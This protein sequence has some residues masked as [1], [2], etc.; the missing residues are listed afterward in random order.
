MPI[1]K[2][3]V[4]GHKGMV[5]SAITQLLK[6]NKIKVFTKTRIQL[7]LTNQAKVYSYLKRTK[8]DCVI[9]AAAKV[10]GIYANDTKPANFL[11]ENLLIES[12]LIHGAYKAGVRRL[13]FLGSSCIY[14]KKTKQPIKEEQLLTGEL[15]LTNYAYAIA[16]IAGIKLCESYNIQ[17]G[18]DFR[19]LMP[20]NLYGPG[21]NYHPMDSHV[22]PSLIRKFHEAKINNKKEV[23]VWGTGKPRREFL[24]VTD[25]AKACLFIMR[26]SKA[27]YNKLT[28]KHCSHINVGYGTD[29]TINELAKII[30]NAV[31]FKGKIIFNT[32][33]KD[34]TLRK[35]LDSTKIKKLGW[36]PEVQLQTGLKL[37]YDHF[38]GR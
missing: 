4:A 30:R 25:L 6:K 23:E 2:V 36:K 10:G 17:Y 31:G 18:V 14:P 35:L 29:I 3:Y 15:E 32:R 34:G 38:K 5:G 24:Y 33:M 20:C 1:N 11:N 8:P 12:N 21:D 37:S 16:K 13:I 27:K 26:L 28:D 7:D 19:S 22:I 9:I